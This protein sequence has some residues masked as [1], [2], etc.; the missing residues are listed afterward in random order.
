MPHQ[1]DFINARILH[2]H[3]CG[4]YI[5]IILLDVTSLERMLPRLQRTPVFA[6]VDSIEIITMGDKLVTH[7]GIEEII[8]EPVHIK[9]TTLR[10]GAVSHRFADNSRNNLTGIIRPMAYATHLI[11]ATQH[12]GLP[13][14]GRHMQ[15]RRHAY[16]HNQQ[17]PFQ[18][19]HD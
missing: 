5:G 11:T 9:H 6:Q 14:A 13:S 17:Y 3:E 10:G 1:H 2:N 15:H 8:V 7:T 19:S 16:K 12:I 18:S 4:I